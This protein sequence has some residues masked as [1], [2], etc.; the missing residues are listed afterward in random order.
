MR[1]GRTRRNGANDDSRRVATQD[2]HLS[3]VLKRTRTG[4]FVQRYEKVDEHS[5]AGS[6]SFQM[7]F[8][9][10]SEFEQFCRSDE[11]RFEHPL[12]YQALAREFHDL[13]HTE[14]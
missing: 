8:T 5:H 12:V 6:V 2:E 9:T 7:L 10:E 14:H 4:V 13:L 11:M 1:H 3:F